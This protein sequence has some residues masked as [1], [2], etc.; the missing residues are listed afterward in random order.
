MATIPEA[1]MRAEAAA[2]E[3][4]YGVPMALEGPMQWMPRVEHPGGDTLATLP[5]PIA[6]SPV[7]P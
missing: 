6:P 4:R 2:V 1:Q 3:L 5:V 7:A